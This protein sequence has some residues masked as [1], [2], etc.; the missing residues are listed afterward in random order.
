MNSLPLVAAALALAQTSASIPSA[1]PALTLD[2]ALRRGASANL[3]LAVARF[4]LEQARAGVAKA[5]S[6]HLPQVTAGASYTRNS[7]PIAVSLPTS[8]YV[9]DTGAPAGPPSSAQ[10][11]GQTPLVASIPMG[12]ITSDIQ[13]VDQLG[14][15]VEASQAL[16]APGL[17]FAIRAASQ[18]E[19]AAARSVEAARRQVLFGV[20]QAYYGAAS[21]KRL[22]DVSQRLLEIARRQEKD[23]QARFQA[24]TIPRVGVL[25][26]GIDRVGAEQ[27]VRRSQNAYESA[28]VSLA[29]LLDRDAAFEVVDPP[30]PVVPAD[31]SALKDAALRE[32]PDVQAARLTAVAAASQRRSTAMRYLPSLGAFG[33]WQTSNVGG[34]T[35]RSDSWAVGVGLSWGVLDGG[36]REAELREGSARVGEAEAAR[37]LA[38]ARAV[39]EVQQALLDLASARA[40]AAKAR[41]QAELAAENQRLVDVAFQAGAATA[42]EQADATATYR[43]A[44]VAATAE[45]LQAQLAALRVQQAAGSFDP[46]P[47]G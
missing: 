5:W 42:V 28:K 13:K 26:A 7:D 22:L 32:R 46:V 39:A 25:R 27:D 11:G 34:F 20:A 2:D 30:E 29:L 4:R 16:I 45:A 33:R 6:L 10:D 14:A 23:A 18:G 1:H 35:G 37:R 40:N 12:T 21:M 19:A 24:G 31:L 36:L 38:E 43:N 41:E 8:Y 47:S 9:R 44:A 17:W 15:K 3:D